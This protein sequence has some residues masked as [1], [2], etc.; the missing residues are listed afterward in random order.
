MAEHAASPQRQ[1]TPAGQERHGEEPTHVGVC[2]PELRRRRGGLVPEL[3]FA[4][5]GTATKKIS[6]DI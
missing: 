4:H 1:H 5:Q 2:P 3:I 6:K